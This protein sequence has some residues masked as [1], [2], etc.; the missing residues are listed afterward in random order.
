MKKCTKCGIEKPLTE[1]HKN[2]ASKDGLCNWC[3]SCKSKIKK[4]Y[5]KRPDVK[6]RRREYSK[7]YYGRNPRVKKIKSM[8]LEA[9]PT[10]PTDKSHNFYARRLESKE[11]R[12]FIYEIHCSENNL[13]YIGQ[14]TVGKN[15]WKRHLYNLKTNQHPN[16][17]LQDTYDKFGEDS[18]SFTVIKSVKHKSLLM[19]EEVKIISKYL[20]E[21]KTL[22]NIH[23]SKENI[24][25]LIRLVVK[26]KEDK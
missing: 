2:S 19:E 11:D 26:L 7:I 13:Y 21:E 12:V 10:L 24:A 14:T 5:L 16:T 17:I 9:D 3:K 15:R 20:K 1:F 22:C 25:D 4:E 6:R 8:A 23:L 18:L